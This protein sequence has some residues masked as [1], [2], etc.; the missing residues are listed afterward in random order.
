MAG[1]WQEI[2][3][4]AE[5]MGTRFASWF[6]TA[7][8]Y[9]ILWGVVAG[10]FVVLLY[11]DGVFSRKLAADSINPLSFQAMGWVYRFF[12]AAFLMAAARCVYKGIKGKWTFRL[13]GVFAS[14]IVCLHAWGFGFEA[15]D[16][17]RDQALAAQTVAS[18]QTDTNAEIIATLEAQK[19]QIDADTTAAVAALDAEIRQYITDGINNDDLA[20]DSRARRTQLQDAAITRK[21]DLDERI[22]SLKLANVAPQEQ[23]AQAEITAEPWAP[24]FVGMAQLFTWTKEPSDWAIYICAIMFVVCW[25]LLG[26]CLVIFLPERIYVMHLA[27][28]EASKRSEAAKKGH[29]TRREKEEAADRESRRTGKQIEAAQY[30][31]QLALALLDAKRR[32]P[33][34]VMDGMLGVK[35]YHTENV[36]TVPELIGILDKCLQY[37]D[38]TQSEYDF[39]VGTPAVNGADKTPPPPT[40]GPSDDDAQPAA[41]V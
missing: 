3:S 25:V 12:A 38:L 2:K 36:R 40:E 24:I 41:G 35:K 26:E 18:V 5:W 15:L 13:L 28:A 4:A 30:Y 32:R 27:D 10:A 11:I 21:Q 7:W 9:I 6:T 20:D 37:G 39:L 31:N 23:A 1:V 34:L 14:L 17:R 19:A 33:R 22:I 16:E 8:L 29:E